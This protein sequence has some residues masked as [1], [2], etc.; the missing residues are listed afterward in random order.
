MDERKRDLEVRFSPLSPG[1]L[2]RVECV[3]SRPGVEVLDVCEEAE[4]VAAH[5]IVDSLA[6]DQ[7]FSDFMAMPEKVAVEKHP[8]PTPAEA[9]ARAQQMR[10]YVARSR[11]AARRRKLN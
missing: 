2:R 8:W 11:E 5:V 3:L 4:F 7:V 9:E 6:F 10:S 1:L